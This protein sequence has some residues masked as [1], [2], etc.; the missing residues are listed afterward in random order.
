MDCYNSHI[1]KNAVP[2][3]SFIKPNLICTFIVSK[4]NKI[5][6]SEITIRTIFNNY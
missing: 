1:K 2:V 5:S 3:A 4:N 6:K